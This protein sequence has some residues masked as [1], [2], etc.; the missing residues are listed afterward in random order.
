[1]W[2]DHWSIMKPAYFI[3]WLIFNINLRVSLNDVP[4]PK[5]LYSTNMWSTP[6]V[7]KQYNKMAVLH[8]L[9]LNSSL[10]YSILFVSVPADRYSFF[11]SLQ[12]QLL[13]KI[14]KLRE[15]ILVS[16][17]LNVEWML[18]FIIQGY[19]QRMRL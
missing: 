4:R 18:Y 2:N 14:L 16:D 1:M 19:L 17:S 7:W 11:F 10:I 8:F 9:L 13:T 6:A 15:K 3:I 5:R 12:L